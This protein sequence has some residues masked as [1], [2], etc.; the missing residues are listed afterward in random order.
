M[1]R[2]EY[3]V[4]AGGWVVALA[5]RRSRKS[6]GPTLRV[7]RRRQP[8]HPTLRAATINAWGI[9]AAKS[10]KIWRIRSSIAFFEKLVN[11][12]ADSN[13]T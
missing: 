12:P 13:G 9:A 7:S 11:D 10:D 3:G 4:D 1:T 8:Q 6:L 2:L 5:G